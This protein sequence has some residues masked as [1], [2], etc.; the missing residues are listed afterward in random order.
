VDERDFYAEIRSI[1]ED[2]LDE[3]VSKQDMRN[4]LDSMVDDLEGE[5]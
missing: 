4:Q 1:A 5:E 3:G 2:W